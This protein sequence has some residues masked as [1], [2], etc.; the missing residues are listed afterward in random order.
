MRST[1]LGELSADNDGAQATAVLAH[2]VIGQHV[3]ML[4][5]DDVAGRSAHPDRPQVHRVGVGSCRWPGRPPVLLAAVDRTA[6]RAAITVGRR[7]SGLPGGVATRRVHSGVHRRARRYALATPVGQG[8]G[9]AEMRA[10]VLG[11]RMPMP[12]S[13]RA[14][15]Y[16]WV[17]DGALLAGAASRMRPHLGAHRSQSASPAS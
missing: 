14:V 8:S 10:L 7:A 16:G 6:L 3:D 5:V 12:L 2:I 15:R 1:R 11:R 13:G 9:A 17:R 4:P